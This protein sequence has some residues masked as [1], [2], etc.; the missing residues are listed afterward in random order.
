MCMHYVCDMIT[1]KQFAF[2]NEEHYAHVNNILKQLQLTSNTDI[3]YT[4]L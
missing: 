4:V 2:Y 1:P 3:L